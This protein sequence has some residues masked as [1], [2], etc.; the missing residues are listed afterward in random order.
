MPIKASAPQRVKAAIITESL[1]PLRRSRSREL[2][3]GTV[4][5]P[6]DMKAPSPPERYEECNFPIHSFAFI[7]RSNKQWSYAIVA[8]RPVINGDE[9]IRFVTDALGSTKI[10]KRRHWGKYIRLPVVG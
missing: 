3:L 4:A 6:F 8:D 1:P 5:T 10:L 2:D 7:L 9:C